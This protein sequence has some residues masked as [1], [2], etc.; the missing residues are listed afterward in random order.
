MIRPNDYGDFRVDV[1]VQLFGEVQWTER[2]I[3][4][5]LSAF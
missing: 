2:Q 1:V 3:Y 4:T 5:Q